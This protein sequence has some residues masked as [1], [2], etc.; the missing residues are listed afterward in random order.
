MITLLEQMN[1]WHWL[2][3][4][5]LLLAGELLGTAGYFLW[6]GLSALLVAA[7]LLVLPIGWEMQWV[8]FAVFSL[9]TTWQWWRYQ[10]NKDTQSDARRNLNQKE[11]QLIG[12]TTRLTESVQRGHFRLRLGDSTWRA[13]CDQDLEQGTLVKV[14]DVDGI[15]LFVTKAE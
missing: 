12:K 9:V 15:T 3:F 7:I 5:L 4:G 8:C 6:L 13:S 14:T 11:K 1:H 2:A 10:H